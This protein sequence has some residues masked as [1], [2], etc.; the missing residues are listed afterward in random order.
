MTDTYYRDRIAAAEREAENAR[1]ARLLA[2][3]EALTAVRTQDDEVLDAEDLAALNQAQAVI[4]DL[5]RTW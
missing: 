4:T 2:L 5:R 3:D 1:A